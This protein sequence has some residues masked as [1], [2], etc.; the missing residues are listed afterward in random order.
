MHKVY[1]LF[2]R[3]DAD[4]LEFVP[5]TAHVIKNTNFDSVNVREFVCFAMWNS[6]KKGTNNTR[7]TLFP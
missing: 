2:L 6:F 5:A 7:L 1:T 3:S 4:K